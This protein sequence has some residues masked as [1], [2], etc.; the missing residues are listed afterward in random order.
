MDQPLSFELDRRAN[1]LGAS[2]WF[3]TGEICW[4]YLAIEEAGA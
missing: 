3:S 1:F 4:R 2:R